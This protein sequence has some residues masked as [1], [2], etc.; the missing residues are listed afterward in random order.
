MDFLSVSDEFEWFKNLKNH[1]HLRY[2][3]NNVNLNRIVGE[4][5]NEAFDI[6][7]VVPVSEEIKT[8]SDEIEDLL[9]GKN[10][11]GFDTFVRDRPNT[12]N[13]WLILKQLLKLYMTEFINRK[14]FQIAMGIQQVR[15]M[16]DEDNTSM[17]N[18]RLEIP[19]V[20]FFLYQDLAPDVQDAIRSS[21]SGTYHIP[22]RRLRP[23]IVFNIKF[24]D[25]VLKGTI[26]YKCKLKE[27]ISHR[28]HIYIGEDR[29]TQWSTIPET[30]NFSAFAF[31]HAPEL[32]FGSL[33][34]QTITNHIAK[35]RRRPF[36]AHLPGSTKN[37]FLI[38]P[39][40][41]VRIVDNWIH[42]FYHMTRIPDSP[43]TINSPPIPEVYD[44]VFKIRHVIDEEYASLNDMGIDFVESSGLPSYP[45]VLGGGRRRKKEHES[46]R[47]CRATSKPHSRHDRTKTS[48]MTKRK[49]KERHVNFPFRGF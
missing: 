39:L 27:Q 30:L 35:F 40:T 5:V 19:E 13:F 18:A 21:F 38:D 49:K 16:A 3:S 43:Y 15:W 8:L 10:F 28:G 47:R 25:Q 46:R 11:R 37:M 24:I 17:K 26:W 42:D 48:Q 12:E 7:P 2:L 14:T 34:S 1:P 32:V 29:K 36:A 23:S 45:I 22:M 4:I 33:K 6:D 31:I 20:E 44:K 9:F 41:K